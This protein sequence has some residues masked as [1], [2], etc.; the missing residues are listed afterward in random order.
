MVSLL[1]APFAFPLPRL[2][3]VRRLSWCLLALD[4]LSIVSLTQE[5]RASECVQKTV[6]VMFFFGGLS[7]SA[8][9]RLP[10]PTRMS[11]IG[12]L[13][14]FSAPV[15]GSFVGCCDLKTSVASNSTTYTFGA[16]GSCSSRFIWDAN[17]NVVALWVCFI[18][19]RSHIIHL[20]P[21]D[22]IC[23]FFNKDT[24]LSSTRPRTCWHSVSVLVLLSPCFCHNLLYSADAPIL[25]SRHK[26]AVFP[27]DRRCM[28]IF[29]NWPPRLPAQTCSSRLPKRLA[30]ACQFRQLR[31][32][33]R[34]EARWR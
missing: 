28:R 5:Q 17:E 27:N 31:C 8:H 14:R 6:S 9:W 21:C 20:R 33:R 16:V 29:G 7:P 34:S 30:I 22:R 26:G 13:T 3:R 32:L 15:H 25:C 18:L 24:L 23:C 2:S 1:S 12:Y 11:L 10:A 19:L 4:V